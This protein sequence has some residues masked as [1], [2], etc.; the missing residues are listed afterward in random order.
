MELVGTGGGHVTGFG[1][2]QGFLDINRAHL[3]EI[4]AAPP[5]QSASKKA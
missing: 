3:A 2:L 4:N 5:G 1:T